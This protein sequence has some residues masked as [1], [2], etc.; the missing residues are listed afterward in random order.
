MGP[1]EHS[2]RL[3]TSPWPAQNDPVGSTESDQK[4]VGKPYCWAA[5]VWKMRE[6]LL[7]SRP[8]MSST[9]VVIS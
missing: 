1:G 9:E 6:G 7:P 4:V 5:L 2:S 8:R 3:K